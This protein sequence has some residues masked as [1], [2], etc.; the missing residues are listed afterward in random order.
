MAHIVGAASLAA[1]GL[2]YGA[3]DFVSWEQ[4]ALDS[5][6]DALLKAGFTNWPSARSLLTAC[7]DAVETIEYFLKFGGE[8]DGSL[9]KSDNRTKRTGRAPAAGTRS[10]DSV[11]RRPGSGA[12]THSNTPTPSGWE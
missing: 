7:R 8:Y 2:G 6:W 4:C 11:V 1:T 5:R 3:G 9:M 12:D 10:S